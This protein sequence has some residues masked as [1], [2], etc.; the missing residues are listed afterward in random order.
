MLDGVGK[1]LFSRLQTLILLVKRDV[2]FV[3][4]S[5]DFFDI[6]GDGGF[7]DA[8]VVS[9]LIELADE[10]SGSLQCTSYYYP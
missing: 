1:V 2:K 9:H 5:T 3:G 6:G 8:I 4:H 10:D 7:F